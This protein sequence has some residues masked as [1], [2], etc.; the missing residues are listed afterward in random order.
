MENMDALL[1]ILLL[2]Q[3]PAECCRVFNNPVKIP[4]W[5]LPSKYRTQRVLFTS[6]P[7][8]TLTQ[9]PT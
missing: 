8:C 2:K 5:I 7:I 4:Q 9:M 1:A 3:L 6:V